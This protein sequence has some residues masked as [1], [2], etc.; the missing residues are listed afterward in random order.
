LRSARS[1]GVSWLSKSFTGG[2]KRLGCPRRELRI[3]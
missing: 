3:D 2:G 1:G